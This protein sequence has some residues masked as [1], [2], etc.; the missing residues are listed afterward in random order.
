M[1][2]HF[3]LYN[4]AIV[5]KAHFSAC[6]PLLKSMLKRSWSYACNCTGDTLREMI[7]AL[8]LFLIHHGLQIPPPKKKNRGL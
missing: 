3:Y 4:I 8:Y 7:Y 1:K 2:S 6:P 5:L